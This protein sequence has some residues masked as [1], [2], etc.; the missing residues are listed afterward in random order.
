MKQVVQNYKTGEL[1]VDDVPA[2]AG[3]KAS[4]LVTNMY[5][6]ISAGTEKST[7]DM[8]KKSLVGKAKARPDLVKKVI[9]QIQKDGLVDTAKMVMGRLDTRAALGY[10]CA[11][12]VT[13]VGEDVEGFSVGDRVACAGQNYA[14]HAEVVSI[15]KNLCI[16]VPDNVD[17]EDAAYAA[18]GSIALQGVRQADPKLGDIVA[19]VGLGLLGQIVV[20]MLKANGC[21]VVATDLDPEKVAMAQSFGADRAVSAAEFQDACSSISDG[22]GV[23][24]V[25][26]T[27]STKSNQPIET[28]GEVCRKKGRVVVVGAV[29]M[30]IPREPYYVKELELRLSM[31]YGP[32]RYD[33]DYEEKGIDY[34]YGYVRWTEKRNME[35]FLNLIASG[36]ISIKPLTSH[37]FLI[38]DAETAY[39]II[40]SG[41]E[42][43]LGIL[44]TYAEEEQE[45]FDTKKSLKESTSTPPKSVE[46]GLI[47]VGNHIKDMLLPPLRKN[48]AVNFKAVCTNTGINS[49]AVAEK[50][51]AD[52]CT[53]NYQEVI[54]DPSINAIIIGTRHDSHAEIVLAALKADKHVFVEKP[55]CMTKDELVMIEEAYNA[56][57]KNLVLQAGFNRRYSVHAEKIKNVFEP[58]NNPL[59]MIY[60]VNAGAIPAEHWI[61]DKE[62]GGGRIVGEACHFVDFMQYICGADP[63]AIFA[64]S[65]GS[66]DSGISND[67]SI[68]TITFS[69]GS[70]GT[71]IY[72]ADGDKSLSKERFEAFAD[73]KSVVMD[74]FLTTDI[75]QSGKKSTFKTR[76]RD[77]GFSKEVND[78]VTRITSAENSDELFKQAKAVTLTTIE[79]MESMKSR[80]FHSVE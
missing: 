65:V 42:R 48:S 15:P 28:A 21:R 63:V 8:A 30:D 35:A 51:G 40:T 32:G 72:A 58:Q 25:I 9:Q 80:L 37:K 33:T 24:S 4:V 56:S 20:Q 34:P 18:V 22:H 39:Q 6:L 17:L 67:K 64:V 41:S 3:N 2:P 54:D 60:R 59:T 76:V 36:S 10:T 49:K 1:K 7:V 43:Y 14:S 73:G 57:S 38:D 52:Y 23:D 79:A 45:K 55:L 62:I 46:L 71:L 68:H 12:I 53:T 44:L 69:N 13:E 78:F 27:A 50:E 47:G 70:I 74:D 61:Q 5:S 26:L 11:G 19:V 29:G 16:K 66:H 75:Y 77:K 31:S